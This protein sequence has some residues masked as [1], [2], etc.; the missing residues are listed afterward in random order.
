MQPAVLIIEDIHLLFGKKEVAAHET[1]LASLLG[2][3]DNANEELIMTIATYNTE[4]ELTNSIRSSGK[5]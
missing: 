3:L 1:T 4:R 2:E 5:F